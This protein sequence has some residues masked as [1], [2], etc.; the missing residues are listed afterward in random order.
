MFMPVYNANLKVKNKML[1]YNENMLWYNEYTL[2]RFRQQT[3]LWVGYFVMNPSVQWNEETAY[4]GH[5]TTFRILSGLYR[6]T[7]PQNPLRKVIEGTKS[8]NAV[9]VRRFV[10]ADRQLDQTSYK[11]YIC[12]QTESTCPKAVSKMS[13]GRTLSRNKTLAIRSIEKEYELNS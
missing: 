10:P 4:W 11:I 13:R 6:T 2:L 9:T 12:W 7:S 3:G 1:I 8:P 5:N